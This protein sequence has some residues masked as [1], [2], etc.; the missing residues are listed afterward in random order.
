MARSMDSWAAASSSLNTFSGQSPHIP[1]HSHSHIFWPEPRQRSFFFSASEASAPRHGVRVSDRSASARAAAAAI[2]VCTLRH[3]IHIYPSTWRGKR[4]WCG[5]H[6]KQLASCH[7]EARFIGEE[8]ASCPR[9]SSRFLRA[10]TRRFGM[11]I[12]F[13]TFQAASLTAGCSIHSAV[14]DVWVRTVLITSGG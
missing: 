9:R 11:T 4:L 13:G 6:Q 7:S 2:E 3:H 8:S 12:H 5:L 1:L 10:T 14:C